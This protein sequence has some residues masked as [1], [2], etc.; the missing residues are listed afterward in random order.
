MR[1]RALD[2]ERLARALRF[3]HPRPGEDEV[4]RRRRQRLLVGDRRANARMRSR[5]AFAVAAGSGAR[6]IVDPYAVA[7]GHQHARR[8]TSFPTLKGAVWHGEDRVRASRLLERA[9]REHRLGPGGGLL[10][11]LEDQHHRA[12]EAILDRRESLGDREADRGVHV[13][14]ADVAHA[15]LSD[16]NSAGSGSSDGTA[17]MS[18]R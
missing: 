12:R 2:R 15:G 11:R 13:V 18:A 14:A 7:A 6:S 1:D 5:T 3:E 16:L 9:V 10:R 17:S 8:V 4:D